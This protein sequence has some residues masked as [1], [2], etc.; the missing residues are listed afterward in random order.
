MQVIGIQGLRVADGSI[1]PEIISGHTNI[2]I[3]MIAE[4]LADM[5]KEDW[6]YSN[7]S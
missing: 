2:P 6:G 4:K 1:M 5:V 3:F 7:E